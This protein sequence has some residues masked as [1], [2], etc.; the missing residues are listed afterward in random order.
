MFDRDKPQLL[1]KQQQQ[2]SLT[3]SHSLAKRRLPSEEGVLCGARVDIDIGG[4]GEA[5]GG[6]GDGSGGIFIFL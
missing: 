5:R 3:V 2:P 1:R 4:G 6:E